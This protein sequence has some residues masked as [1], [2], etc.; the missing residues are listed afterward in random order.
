MKGDAIKKKEEATAPGFS[1][2]L[3]DRLSS[4]IEAL[5]GL[6][7][8][9]ALAGVTDEQVSKWRSGRARLPFHAAAI[10]ADE[11]GISLDWLAT[12]K[13]PKHRWQ[14][15]SGDVAED[16]LSGVIEEV[17]DFVAQTGNAWS[18]KK[19]ARVVSAGYALI[20][21]QQTQ[22]ESSASPLSYLLK[23]AS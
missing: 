20:N 1:A 21:Q 15:A 11:T 18:A 8:A 9:G 23:A 16:T 4:A 22:G 6:R 19:K 7:A 10:W 13:E 5:G 12:G 3:G 14:T 17:D 2:D